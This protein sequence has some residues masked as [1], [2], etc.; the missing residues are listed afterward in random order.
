MQDETIIKDPIELL[1][2]IEE[3]H[4]SD[5]ADSLKKIKKNNDD[6]FYDDDISYRKLDDHNYIFEGKTALVDISK[7]IETFF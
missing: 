3:L 5:I 4:P 1:E 6:E 2:K 7:I